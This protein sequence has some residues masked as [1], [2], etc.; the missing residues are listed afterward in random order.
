[1]IDSASAV[2]YRSVLADVLDTPVPELPVRDDINAFK[3]FDDALTLVFFQAVLEDVLHDKTP[4]LP[5][6]DFMPHALQ[7][8]VD[9]SHD[10][11]WRIAP[12]E[13][14]QLLPYVACIAMNNCLGDA[15]EQLMHHDCFVLLWHA[16]KRLLHNVA[17]EC[18]HAEVEGIPANRLCDGHDLLW[19]AVL[20][21]T[22][23]KEV[24]EAVD[25][26]RVGLVDDGTHDLE[27]LVSRTY[28]ELLLKEDRGLL[29][30]VT[31]DLVNDVLP[32]ATH[33]AIKKTAIVQWLS[34]SNVGRTLLRIRR[35]LPLALQ[36]LSE[37]RCG[38]RQSR[39]DR[40]MRV[41]HVTS[42]GA[43]RWVKA[44]RRDWRREA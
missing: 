39:S 30:V 6:G 28:F 36:R 11:W 23:N 13:L 8:L 1:M 5:E 12:A 24:S 41:V 22:L 26:Q 42:L 33:V 34:C 17:A 20:E 4:S 2:L 15:A 44:Q 3:D 29:V 35:L 16:V 27:F 31:H 43:E 14:E 9:V 32:I 25:H 37:Y 18:I 21:A 19:R 38:G 10:L 40:V 7:S